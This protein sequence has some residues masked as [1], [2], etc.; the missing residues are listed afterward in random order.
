MNDQN[1]SISHSSTLAEIC[2]LLVHGSS[3]TVN[4]GVT[5][6]AHQI[7]KIIQLPTQKE[8]KRCAKKKTK[9][10]PKRKQ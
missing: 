7:P 3:G 5:G 2:I 8:P 10:V 9:Q 1:P 6:A 4:R